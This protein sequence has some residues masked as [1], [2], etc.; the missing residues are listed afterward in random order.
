MLRVFPT[1]GGLLLETPGV[2][3]QRWVPYGGVGGFPARLLA[4]LNA[5]VR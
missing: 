3:R 1:D 4:F 2:F 5:A